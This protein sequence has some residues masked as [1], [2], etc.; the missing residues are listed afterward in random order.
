MKKII[1][2]TLNSCGRCSSVKESLNE[3]KI[4]FQE[5]EVG[6]HQELWQQVID[7][8]GNTYVPTIFVTENDDL[9]N[10]VEGFIFIPGKDFD[11]DYD[12]IQ[13]LKTIYYGN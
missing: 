9:G 13:K 4:P 5:F 6:E 2:F 1:L 7:Q 3:F 10:D 8:T 12:L 11:T